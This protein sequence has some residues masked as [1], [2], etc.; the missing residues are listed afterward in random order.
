MKMNLSH[1]NCACLLLGCLSM[2]TEIFVDVSAS[3]LLE[4]ACAS[5]LVLSQTFV[6]LS[7]DDI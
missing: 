4:F 5:L 1:V 2:N 7:N 6:P 3:N